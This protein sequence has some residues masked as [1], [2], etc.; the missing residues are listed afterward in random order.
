VAV[1]I[2]LTFDDGPDP[3][4]TREV[5]AL[6]E[7]H[8]IRATFFIFGERAVLY[9]EVVREVI[10]AGHVVQPH[11][12]SH[13]SHHALSR[14]EIAA[15]IDRVLGLLAG[16]GA[17]SPTLRRPPNGELRAG[18]S[19]AIAA[20]R[21][22]AL[23]GWTVTVMDWHPTPGGE[24]FQKLVRDLDPV[25]LNVVLMHDG[26][27]NTGQ[28]RVDSSNTI[29]ALGRLLEGPPRDYVLVERGVE[30]TLSASRVR[31]AASRWVL[32]RRPRSLPQIL[33]DP[34][35]H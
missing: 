29:D 20:E 15:D 1:Q 4:G 14:K 5:L 31:S 19:R 22:L 28:T 2:A 8:G 7:R 23:V 34:N 21:G 6:L 25:A 11:C 24:L 35:A 10:A 12:W 3:V 32:A 27:T 9:P 26:Y 13:T 17:P 30:T 16:L 18:V 33:H